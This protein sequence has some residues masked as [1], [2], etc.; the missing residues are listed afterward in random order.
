M[1]IFV[2]Y[3]WKFIRDISYNETDVYLCDNILV[4]WKDIVHTWISLDDPAHDVQGM[5]GMEVLE[6]LAVDFDFLQLWRQ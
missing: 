5:I 4:V 3:Q 6:K 2:W 1:Y